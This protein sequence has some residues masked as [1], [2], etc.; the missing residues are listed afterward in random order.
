VANRDDGKERD[1]ERHTGRPAPERSHVAGGPS[2]LNDVDEMA[3]HDR[4]SD[5]QERN[6]PAAGDAPTR[7][8]LDGLSLLGGSD[9]R[10]DGA[11]GGVSD[12]VRDGSAGPRERDDAPIGAAGAGGR[13]NPPLME[14]AGMGDGGISVSGGAAGGA[15]G[16][17]GTS[18]SGAG[19]PMGDTSGGRAAQFDAASRMDLDHPDT[20]A[21]GGGDDD[22]RER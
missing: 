19:G 2:P 6:A 7:A 5:W 9:P 17:G 14:D 10:G 18:D 12:P 22:R 16:H 20:D 1:I 4:K 13:K 21:S 8:E 11:L 3:L 15:R